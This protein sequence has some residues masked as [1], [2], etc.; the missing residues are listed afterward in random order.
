MSHVPNGVLTTIE[1][2]RLT[3]FDRRHVPRKA[4]KGEI[5]GARRTKSGRHWEFPA[6][7]NLRAWICFYRVRHSLLRR[8]RSYK[9]EETL[10]AWGTNWKVALAN[11]EFLGMSAGILR[12]GEA[13][14]WEALEAFVLRIG[15]II[16]EDGWVKST[17]RLK[18][19][20]REELMFPGSVQRRWFI[21]SA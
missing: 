8:V 21:S 9:E 12:L 5:P 17:G 18:R 2:A 6:T 20:V 16:R 13:G 14:T 11:Y 7:H 4:A 15:V 3:G 10:R 19:M 1:L